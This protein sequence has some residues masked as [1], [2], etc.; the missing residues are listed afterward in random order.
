MQQH[1]RCNNNDRYGSAAGRDAD[2]ASRLSDQVPLPIDSMS[3]LGAR[4]RTAGVAMGNLDQVCTEVDEVAA[5]GRV[6]TGES[7]T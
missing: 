1:D 4:L 6:D 2:V 5:T 3:A 7:W